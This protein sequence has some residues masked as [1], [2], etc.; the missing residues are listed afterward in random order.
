MEMLFLLKFKI[1]LIGMNDNYLTSEFSLVFIYKEYRRQTKKNLRR[2]TFANNY[3][4]KNNMK[5]RMKQ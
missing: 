2:K 5:N 3:V 1:S 4:L